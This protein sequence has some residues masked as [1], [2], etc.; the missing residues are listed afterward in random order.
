MSLLD[1]VARWQL[2]SNGGG[3]LSSLRDDLFQLLF[4]PMH[5]ADRNAGLSRDRTHAHASRQ[6]WRNFGPSGVLGVACFRRCES[7]RRWPS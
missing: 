2:L 6:Q 7:V 1:R 5:R 3:F 4:R